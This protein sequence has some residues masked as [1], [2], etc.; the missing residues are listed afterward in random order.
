MN[1]S[2]PVGTLENGMENMDDFFSS[3]KTPEGPRKPFKQTNRKKK[4][5]SSGSKKESTK[6]DKRVPRFSIG[7]NEEGN[8]ATTADAQ[9]F[10]K[11][12]EKGFASPGELSQ[13]TT[14]PPSP[15]EAT[16]EETRKAAAEEELLTLPQEADASA[17]RPSDPI[18]PAVPEDDGFPD[19][20]DEDDDL[21]PPPPPES[22]DMRQEDFPAS[23]DAVD[24]PPGDDEEPPATKTSS[25]RKRKQRPEPDFPIDDD[26]DNEGAGFDM[27]SPSPHDTSATSTEPTPQPNQQRGR[28]KKKTSPAETT[29]TKTPAPK[30]RANARN[31]KRTKTMFSPPG[32]PISNREMRPV[33]VSDY[34]ETP[35]AP[36]GVRR[37]QR[38]RYAPLHFWKN[39][40]LV[41]GP[42]SEKGPLAE[43]MGL[44]P[45][46]HQ[47]L[48]A[49]PT[50]RKERKPVAPVVRAA[51][52]ARDDLH[53]EVIKDFDSRKLRKKYRI[54]DGDLAH[55][56]IE[57]EGDAVE[58]SM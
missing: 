30:K 52:V 35:D 1:L 57:A 13:V 36:E 27:T 32:Y 20:D 47:V 12:L 15:K 48:V 53:E 43:D 21:L 18:S 31:K 2:R 51:A 19:H 34:K 25:S 7:D 10:K 39:E 55:V 58:E 14:A 42:H 56:W 38:A 37:S 6:K 33:P 5:I 29:T 22:P 40:R 9:G 54:L 26:D 49:N 46:P 8:T 3:A 17:G 11:K 4:A 45:V 24:F 28:K 23:D 16:P 50:P 41:Y 44:M